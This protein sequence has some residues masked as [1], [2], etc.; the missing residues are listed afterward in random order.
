VLKYIHEGW[1]SKESKT[2]KTKAKTELLDATVLAFP[3]RENAIAPREQGEKNHW[4]YQAMQLVRRALRTP[5]ILIN[6]H[7]M[8]V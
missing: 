2:N 3:T 1:N 8:F 4:G 5:S 7:S 6:D